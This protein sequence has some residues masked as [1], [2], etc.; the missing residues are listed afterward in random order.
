MVGSLWVRNAILVRLIAY[1]NSDDEQVFVLRRH[2]VEQL[3]RGAAVSCCQLLGMG[4]PSF[5]A[6][7]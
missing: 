5:L 3:A 2:M 4:N 7:D 6:K 1:D